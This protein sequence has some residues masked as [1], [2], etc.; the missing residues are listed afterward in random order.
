MEFKLRD[1]NDMIS[2]VGLELLT[3]LRA[4]T[5][6]PNDVF[7]AQY[8]P[9]L[10]RLAQYVQDLPLSKTSYNEHGGAFRFSITALLLTL[11]MADGV[12]FSSS[13][14][15]EQMNKLRPQ[16]RFAAFAA[17]LA[18]V[19]LLVYHHQQ[20]KINGND[21]SY[22]TDGNS[23]H[24]A[25][26]QAGKST[27][28]ITWKGPVE[29]PTPMLATLLL[30]SFFKKGMWSSIHP[31]VVIEMCDAI[32]PA[33]TQSI[34]ETPLCKIVRMGIE[35]AHLIDQRARDPIYNVPV[36]AT[37]M[38]QSIDAALSM[39]MQQSAVHHAPVVNSAPTPVAVAVAVAAPAI[40][41]PTPDDEFEESFLEWA[42]SVKTTAAH[43]SVL[44]FNAN[45]TVTVPISALTGFGVA[46]RDL[47]ARFEGMNLVTT[48]DT[49]AKTI[50]LKSTATRL[51]K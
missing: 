32:N 39:E 38:S 42:N 37:T 31:A 10:Y 25:L 24:E 11:R 5:G 48:K 43:S 7:T 1:P 41:N 18:I 26:S 44:I 14:T 28:T 29:A 46:V 35:K 50:T 19:P 47:V 6:V 27:Y 21:W 16:F 22:L 49:K 23:L 20:I 2:G 40:T 3:K 34:S 33:L 51:F 45:G 13:Y 9:L 4:A 12:L 15:A 30:T 8:L 17:S 36:N